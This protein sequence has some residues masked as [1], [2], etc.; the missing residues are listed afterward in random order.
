M[1]YVV[2]GAGGGE[3]TENRI[4]R[5]ATA[6]VVAVSIGFA[7]IEVARMAGDWVP[8]NAA[9][10]LVGVA[11]YLPL[12]VRH[13]L[14]AVRGYQP[15]GALWTL[16]AM[17]VVV[18]GA[19]PLV[20]AGWIVMFHALAVSVLLL[21]GPPWSFL[22]F[23]ALVAAAPLAAI[24]LGAAWMAHWCAVAVC[25]RGLSLFVLV[26]LVGAVR[27]LQAARLALA[28]DAVL[29]E[30]LRVDGELGA[31]VGTALEEIAA[32][33][34]RSAELAPQDRAAAQAELTE[35]VERARHTLVEARRMISGYQAGSL[36]DELDTAVSLLSAAGIHTRLELPRGGVP[37]L[38]AS[39]RWELCAELRSAAAKL[40]QSQETRNCVITIARRNG[41]VRL[42][43]GVA[44]G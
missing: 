4:V 40:L 8:G 39:E 27:R 33:G 36:R 11:C 7:M 1:T 16:A 37:K 35:L 19:L 18:I 38:A 20:G 3:L 12:H 23:V 24:A 5:L 30:R 14:Y 6:G 32:Q 13:V 42:R 2:D 31:T 17:A 26:W 29:R 21:V 15:A 41:Q 44:A 25:W 34:T 22:I 10:A 43:V 28:E 9:L